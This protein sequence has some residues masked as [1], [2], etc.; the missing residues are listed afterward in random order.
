MRWLVDNCLNT[1]RNEPPRVYRRLGWLSPLMLPGPSL[2]QWAASNS[3]GGRWPI[4][5]RSRRWLNQ[6]THSRVAY[7]TWSMPFQ[8]LRRRMS[9]VVYSP[10]MVSAR[11]LS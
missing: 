5:S 1:T 10:M 3:A 4:G 8:G 9:S 7:S 11:A 2:L 6:S